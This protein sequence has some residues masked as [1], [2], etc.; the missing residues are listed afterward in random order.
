M[1]KE[2]DQLNFKVILNDEDFNRKIKEDLAVAQSFN[3]QMSNVLDIKKQIAKADVESAK[4]TEKIKRE[5]AKTVAEVAK[6]QEKVRQEQ[7]RTEAAAVASLQRQRREIEKTG[8]AAVVNAE[9]ERKARLQT[10]TAQE[11]LNRLI[12]QGNTHYGNQGRLLRELGGYAATY[13][14]VRTVER[15]ISSLVRVSGEFELQ[16][17]TLKA[18]LQDSDGADR[19]FT[20][21]QQLAVKSPFSFSDLTSYAKQL[22]AFSVP[23]E[24]LYDT[25][26]MLA[27]ISA[28]L[29]VD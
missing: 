5:Q 13:F 3:T 9:K 22:S 16:H 10:A 1:G 27:D 7:S 25:T 18:I 14:S 26:K 28:G 19:I 15:F 17:Q 8:S 21:L 2:I 11:R 12:Q 29:G 20:Q 4:N 6:Q 24:E 23:M